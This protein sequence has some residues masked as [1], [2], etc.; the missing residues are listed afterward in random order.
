MMKWQIWV[1]LLYLLHICSLSHEVWVSIVLH[2]WST[3]VVEILAVFFHL[4]WLC[5]FTYIL[6]PPWSACTLAYQ[7]NFLCLNNSIQGRTSTCIFACIQKHP[8]VSCVAFVLA[9]ACLVRDAHTYHTV[10][11]VCSLSDESGTNM[12]VLTH[13][14]WCSCG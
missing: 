3:G 6:K 4:H 9:S 8:G 13:L 11:Q 10:E 7:L 12:S 5:R 2:A 1:C 14:V